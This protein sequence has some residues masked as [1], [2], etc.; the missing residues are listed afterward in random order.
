MG[1]IITTGAIMTCS[2][3]VMPCVFQ[4]MSNTNVLNKTPVGTIQDTSPA[5]ITT[6]GMCQSIANPM[7]ASATTAALG[8]LTPM[9]CVP[10]MTGSWLPL[11]PTVVIHGIPVLINDSKVFCAYGGVVQFSTYASNVSV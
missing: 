10:L 4:A 9:P 2:F 8:V 3:G 5:S 1:L 11:K 7:V 6:F